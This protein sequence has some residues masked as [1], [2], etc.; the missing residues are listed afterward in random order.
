MGA[1]LLIAVLVAL[2]GLLLGCIPVHPVEIFEPKG[3]QDQGG[4][5]ILDSD[6]VEREIGTEVG[7]LAPNFKAVTLKGEQIELAQFRG[8]YV[9]L[10]FCASWCGPCRAEVPYRLEAYDRFASEGLVMIGIDGDE[11]PETA[12]EYAAE[13]GEVWRHVW[14]GV[15][16]DDGIYALYEINAI[17][18]TVLIDPEGDI[19]ATDLR[20]EGLI[21]GIGDAMGL[22]A[23]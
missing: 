10:A 20:G 8:K 15:W 1:G 23:N 19:V 3:P 17:P 16:S 18:A 5:P 13:K 22:P 6:A 7:M 21:L 9:L 14:D 4:N 2:P 11:D 12:A